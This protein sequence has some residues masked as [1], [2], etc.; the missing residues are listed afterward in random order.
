MS[1]FLEGL[2]PENGL[3]FDKFSEDHG[4]P[5][6]DFPNGKWGLYGEKVNGQAF[7]TQKIY[8]MNTMKKYQI[9]KNF[10]NN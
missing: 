3:E 7:K 9:E 2:L 5:D 8:Q 4:H 6:N 1:K 10:L